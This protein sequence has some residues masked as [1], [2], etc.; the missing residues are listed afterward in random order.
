MT[1]DDKSYNA[2]PLD[3]RV[4]LV[5]GAGRGVG[6][7]LA[8]KLAAA[9]AKIVVADL[10]AK[11][12][13]ETALAI[14]ESRG[15]AVSLAGDVTDESFGEDA[16]QCMLDNYGGVD[17]IVNNAGYIW[18]TSIHKTTDEQ[19]HAMLDCHATAPFRILRAASKFI[20]KAA[21][22]EEDAGLG[23]HRKVVNVSSIAGFYGGATQIA[24]SAGKAAQIGI[25]KTLA[26]E[27]AKYRV[28]VNCV[29]FGWIE[30]RLTQEFADGVP[31]NIDV[32]GKDYAVGF[33]AEA[34]EELKRTI[35]MGRAGTPEEAAGAVFLF[36]LPESD[37]ITGETVVAGGGLLS[38]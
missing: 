24:Y 21:K 5:T 34:R 20:R 22:E 14:R 4:A 16:I 19:W 8:L 12:A 10:D 25:T 18:N 29:G 11:P 7:A 33:S 17:I 26:K 31:T 28:N 6:R 36:C 32:A 37:Y 27:W 9:G 3:G 15:S 2:L 38:V 30:T 23:Y 35:P 1:V 13:E